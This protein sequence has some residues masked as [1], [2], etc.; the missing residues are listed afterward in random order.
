MRV[1]EKLMTSDVQLYEEF[2]GFPDDLPDL[3]TK[4]VPFNTKPEGAINCYFVLRERHE[5]P[6]VY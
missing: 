5:L 2:M 3:R 1:L 6:K 4:R